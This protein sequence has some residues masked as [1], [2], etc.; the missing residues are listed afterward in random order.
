[1]HEEE[2]M[3]QQIFSASSNSFPWGLHIYR[4]IIEDPFMYPATEGSSG[5]QISWCR[6]WELSRERLAS[7]LAPWPSM[8][9]GPSQHQ[10]DQDGA[11]TLQHL[12]VP[13]TPSVL[14][15][16][17]YLGAGVLNAGKT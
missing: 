12:P 15:S 3:K 10:G 11:P 9:W 7:Q 2:E 6:R 4:F 14:L 5:L 16:K 13:S 17:I 8:T 1:M